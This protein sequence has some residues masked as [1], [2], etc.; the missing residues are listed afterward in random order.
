MMQAQKSACIFYGN[1]VRYNYFLYSLIHMTAGS[2]LSSDT[3][4]VESIFTEQ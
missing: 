3:D 1:R 4:S 2:F